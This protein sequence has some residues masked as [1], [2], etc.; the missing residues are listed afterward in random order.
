MLFGWL[1]KPEEVERIQLTQAVQDYKEVVAS[2]N[3]MARTVGSDPVLP[4]EIFRKITGGDAP[5]GPQEIGDCVSWG[6]G[7]ANNYVAVLQ[8]AS[9]LN[10]MGLLELRTEQG[11]WLKDA[12]DHPKYGDAQLLLEEYQETCTEWIYGMS[13]CEIGGQWGDQQDGSVGAWAMKAV[14]LKGTRSRKKFG[15]YDPKRAKSWGANGVPDAE[16]PEALKHL[17]KEAA[18]VT[19][20]T[21]ALPL[22]RAYR[23]IPI[24][25]D[26]GFTEVRDSKGRCYPKGKWMH[27]MLACAV[28]G[29]GWPLIAQSW[30]KISPTGP[31]YLNQ[32]HNTFFC[33]PET[34][35][36][37]L[38]QK[39]SFAPY[40]FMGYEVEDFISWKH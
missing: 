19:S 25:S 15:P 16:E 10:K 37:I 39:D 8:I 2:E 7:N 27:C 13:R 3:L 4:Y 6:W 22:L 14:T 34:F 24:C 20:Y 23:Q 11:T 21:E 38:R 26:Q 33:P 30:G 9:Q 40:G 31:V 1:E 17:F 32:P 12:Q 28:D 29:D 5:S 36:R 18:M 35:D